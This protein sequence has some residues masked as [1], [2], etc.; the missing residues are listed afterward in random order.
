MQEITPKEP[1]WD[2]WPTD[3]QLSTLSEKANGLFHYAA[4]ALQWIEGQI[5]QLGKASRRSV[6]E[7]FTQKGIDPL[8]DLYKLIVTSF[9][10]PAQDA[11]VRAKQLH[12]FQHVIGT[13]LVLEEPLTI[14]QITALLADIPEDDFDV[15]NFLQQFRS[16]L[17]P[18]T[19][20]SFEEATPQMHKS[21]RDYIVNDHAPTEF[22]IRTGHAHFLTARSCLE[23]IVKG[24]SQSDIAWE[25]SVGHWHRHWRKAVEEGTAWEDERMWN[26]FGQMM[27]KEVKVWADALVGAFIDVATAGWGLL[28]RGTNKQK[29]E[30]ISSI[31]MRVEVLCGSL[32][33][34]C[35]SRSLC[36]AFS[37]LV[38]A[39]FPLSPIVRPSIPSITANFLCFKPYQII[40]YHGLLQAWDRHQ[41]PS[42]PV[43]SLPLVSVNKI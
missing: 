41:S 1:D 20:A 13:I 15:V 5:F 31:L 18:G 24:G 42:L 40:W 7:Q 25:Y 14:H 3:D 36:L 43:A 6:F 33:R 34:L 12:G 35:S 37:S 23:V 38:C 22:H 39:S 10:N 26:L 9:N 29:M 30:T 19:T 27:E 21:F 28:K 4:T 8:K 17:I 16:V 2:G 11:T 32:R